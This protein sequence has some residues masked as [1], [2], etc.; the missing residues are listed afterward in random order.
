MN[1]NML[2]APLIK[3]AIV[4]AAFSLIV[5][6]TITSSDGSVWGSLQA[7]L[8]GVFRAVQLVVG[9]VLAL[10]L[11]IAVLIGIF[12]GAVAMVSR[13]TAARMANQLRDTASAR[14]EVVVSFLRSS[15]VGAMVGGHDQEIV[16]MAGRLGRQ[17]EKITRLE[18]AIARIQA[19]LRDVREKS[20]Q[21]RR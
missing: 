18:E 17:E 5:Y 6:L 19:E 4:L 14:L 8:L 7:I 3:S 2:R 9:L 12:L 13:E 15:R 21:Q 11:C 20:G 16:E 10:I 1:D